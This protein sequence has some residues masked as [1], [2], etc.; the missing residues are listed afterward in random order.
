MPRFLQIA[1]TLS[2][3]SMISSSLSTIQGPAIKKKFLFIETLR[4]KKI[5]KHFV[6]VP[7]VIGYWNLVFGIWNLVFGIWYLGF[8]IC[9]F[10]LRFGI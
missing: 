1:E 2:A 9:D 8:V 5:I 3:T 10:G 4:R 6:H 7:K